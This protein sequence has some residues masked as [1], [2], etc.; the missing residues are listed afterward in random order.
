MPKEIVQ[1]GDLDRTCGSQAI[2]ETSYVLQQEEN[3]KLNSEAQ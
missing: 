1:N 3:K 2:V